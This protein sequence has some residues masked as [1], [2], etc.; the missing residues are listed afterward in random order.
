MVDVKV[1]GKASWVTS[2]P[3]TGFSVCLVSRGCLVSAFDF[4]K[5][6]GVHGAYCG[7]HTAEGSLD[8]SL[9]QQEAIERV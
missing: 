8:F 7:C 5:C 4:Q 2:L 9:V 3:R 6:P 1:G